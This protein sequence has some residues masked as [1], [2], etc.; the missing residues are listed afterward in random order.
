MFQPIL[1]INL[2]PITEANVRSRMIAAIGSELGEYETGLPAIYIVRNSDVSPP[3][4]YRANG[5][6]CLIFVPTP[7]S[8]QPLHHNAAL[9][10]FWEIRL[11]QRDRNKSCLAAYKNILAN[12]PDCYLNSSISANRDL[13]EQINLSISQVEIVK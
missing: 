11:I 3:K 8:P 9:F 2:E 7:K 12:Y 10:E 13:D 5:L 1:P 4:N 6:E